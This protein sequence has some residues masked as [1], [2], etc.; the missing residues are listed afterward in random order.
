M[1]LERLLHEGQRRILVA[2]LRHEALQD[3]AFLVDR[4]P[5]VDHL[6]VQ[7]DVHLVEVPAPVTDAAHTR[8]PLAPDLAG[9]Q[10]TE[11]VPPH[12]H[13]LVANVDPVFEQQ[14]LDVAQ[15]QRITDLHHHN[16]ADHL[17][18]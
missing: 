2:L 14:V 11:P 12:S 15:R 18:R 1:S 10:R 6:T 3:L 5:Q 4:T 16:E 13:S 9:E 7:L 17:R 8:Q